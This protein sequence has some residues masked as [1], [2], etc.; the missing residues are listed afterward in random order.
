MK[1][2]NEAFDLKRF[3]LEDPLYSRYKLEKV[4]EEDILDLIAYK[5]YSDKI[6]KLE[7]I[8]S[9]CV[10][11]NK[12]T[13]FVSKSNSS[14]FI[15]SLE[16]DYTANNLR[17]EYKN[18]LIEELNRQS[19]FV[20]KF[21]CPS[22]KDDSSHEH[23]F[24][25][26]IIENIIIK[27]GQF[28]SLADLSRKQIDEYKTLNK[29]IQSEFNTAIGLASHGLGIAPFVYLRR[30]IENHILM[31]KIEELK[32]AKK[33][34]DKQV[35]DA[36]F[37]GKIDLV[38]ERIPEFLVKNKKVYSVLSKGIHSLKEEECKNIFPILRSA[39][40]IMLDEYIEK[41]KKEKKKKLISEQL[42][43]IGQ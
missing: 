26:K 24:I 11:C 6:F 29:E 35:F 34:T 39:I 7:T 14:D 40:E 32:L 16:E 15:S 8:D 22:Q 21:Y 41:E 27:I 38:K 43:K 18:C 5:S 20:R 9:F 28:P 13:T 3:I 17:H 42:K 31:P 1:V 4:S 37:K 30:I 2:N 12:N 36:D 25:F 23:T 33:V 19:I 10:K